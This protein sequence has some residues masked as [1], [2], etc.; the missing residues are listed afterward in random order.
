[1]L[2]SFLLCHICDFHQGYKLP[3]K[4]NQHIFMHL[5]LRRPASLGGANTI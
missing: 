3:E 5:Q 4:I 2:L 1:L